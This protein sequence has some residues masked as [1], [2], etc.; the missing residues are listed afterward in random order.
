MFHGAHL[1]YVG[2]PTTTILLAVWEMAL[3]VSLMTTRGRWFR[4]T[5][6]LIVAWCAVVWVMGEGMGGI[7]TGSPVFP[8]DAPGSTPFYAAGALLLLCPSLVRPTL[9]RWAGAFWGVAALV[10]S[11]P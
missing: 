1:W 9:H 6:W 10:Q 3:G 4:V 2:L 11:L 5:L 8:E 7:L